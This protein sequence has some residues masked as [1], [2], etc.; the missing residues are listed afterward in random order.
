MVSQLEYLAN[1]ELEG[2]SPQ[3]KVEFFTDTRQSFGNTALLL[4]GGATFGMFHLGVVKCL[5]ENDLLPRIIAGTSVGAL[6]AS[7]V[8]A[9]EDPELPKIFHSNGINLSAF[10]KVG[11][12]GSIKRK[13][14]RLLKHGR[15]FRD[16]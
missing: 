9:H 12:R 6:I 16:T 7:L 15:T 11:D 1:S 5:H 10:S 13:F 14:L 8:C 4:N 2:L 3:A